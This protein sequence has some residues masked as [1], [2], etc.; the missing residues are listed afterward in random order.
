VEEA[1]K[2][3]LYTCLY[4]PIEVD[5]LLKIVEKILAEKT[6]VKSQQIGVN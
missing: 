3:N 5:N 1:I 2:Q 4:K 6:K